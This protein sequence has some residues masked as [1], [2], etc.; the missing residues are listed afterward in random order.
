MSRDVALLLE[1]LRTKTGEVELDVPAP[2][3][4]GDAAAAARLAQARQAAIRRG[5]R[6]AYLYKLV[7]GRR[8][9]GSNGAAH[10]PDLTTA[11]TETECSALIAAGAKWI[12][13]AEHAPVARPYIE[14]VRVRNFRC[15]QEVDFAL[16]PLHALIGPNDSGKS[17]L[18]EALMTFSAGRA[19]GQVTVFSGT[20]ALTCFPD[21]MLGHRPDIP[22]RET[23]AQLT[24]DPASRSALQQ[25]RVEPLHD[26][27]V[28]PLAAPARALR[29]DPDAMREPTNLIA[30][31]EPLEYSERGYGL[32]AVYDAFLSR[33]IGV[34]L[35]I[36]RRFT[37]LFPTARS[38]QLTNPSQTTKAIGVELRD[39]QSVG[40]VRLS[41]G[42][43]YWLAFA[44][45][46]YLQRTPFI[47]IEEPE[48]GLHPSRIS[49]VM[50][51]LREISKTSQVIVATHHPLV[52]NELQSDEVTIITR[53]PDRGT[54]AT[55]LSRTKNFEQRSKVYALGELWLNYADG[56]FESDLVDES[57]IPSA[58]G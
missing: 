26:D 49:D 13:P 37:A 16:T 42:M 25:S 11:V 9:T 20:R 44:A 4:S 45:L 36:S 34:F 46:P 38:I 51:V 22:L 14:R 24:L 30:Q 6:V 55:P 58:A 56:E 40:A 28:H 57:T 32:A 5:D 12:G 50:Q 15:I 39:G 48:N 8:T 1:H 47:V 33:R 7:D 3:A 10:R 18:L 27:P 41:E 54:I 21:G 19:D 2:Q 31:G 53:T 29:L 52:I 17:T 35:E 43:L 23:L